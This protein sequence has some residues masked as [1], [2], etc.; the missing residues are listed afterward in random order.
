MR[1]TGLKKEKKITGGTRIV[2]GDGITE[3]LCKSTIFTSLK[4]INI[5]RVNC[6]YKG[7][8]NEYHT[9]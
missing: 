7:E 3:A 6:G 1:I 9:S 4:R 2:G 5:A 8:N